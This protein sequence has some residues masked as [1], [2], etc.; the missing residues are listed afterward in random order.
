MSKNKTKLI[1]FRQE[2]KALDLGEQACYYLFNQMSEGLEI[3][4]K[5]EI[6]RCIQDHL[7]LMPAMIRFN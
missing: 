3:M 1:F 4:T 5:A 6:R 7:E 2:L